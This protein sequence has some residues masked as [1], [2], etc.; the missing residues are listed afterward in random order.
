MARI[1][2]GVVERLLDE[3][4]GETIID[5]AE[6]VVNLLAKVVGIDAA[7][8]DVEELVLDEATEV[9]VMRDE[10][11]GG[12]WIVEVPGRVKSG[13]MPK[14]GIS[15]GCLGGICEMTPVI[16]NLGE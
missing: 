2:T 5:C 3:L 16:L 4:V 6:E 10:V 8:D 9:V 15:G 13:G 7:R 1:V 12:L 14:V 11:G